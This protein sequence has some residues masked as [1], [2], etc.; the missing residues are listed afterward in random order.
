MLLELLCVG[1]QRGRGVDMREDV[2]FNELIPI[3]TM[4]EMFLQAVCCTLA[5]QFCSGCLERSTV[6]M[7][8]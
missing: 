4:L 6:P 1:L 2:T 7:D 5:R 3:G 8:A